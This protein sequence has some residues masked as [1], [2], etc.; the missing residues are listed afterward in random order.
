MRES[1][2]P[3]HARI[4][5]IHRH[6]RK[7]SALL[8]EDPLQLMKGAKRCGRSDTALTHRLVVDRA[9][10]SIILVMPSAKTALSLRI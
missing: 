6:A 5:D 3:L 9:L 10:A 8:G 7:I 4:A 1:F 2:Q